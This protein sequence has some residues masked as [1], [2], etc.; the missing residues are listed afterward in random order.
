MTIDRIK[1]KNYRSLK[2]TEVKFSE[3][4]NIIV[5]DNEAGKSTLLEAINLALRCQLNR[6]PAQY[7]LHPYLINLETTTEFVTS[8][9]AG[10]PIPPPEV[11]I[12]LY[13]KNT[14]E[15]AD[16][17][18]SINSEK[19][20][21]SGISLAIKLDESFKAEYSEYI[22]DLDALNG[23]P[24]EYYEIEWLS[25]A[26]QPLTAQAIQV[27]SALIDP[28]NISNSYAANKYVLEMVR[29]Y[30]TKSQSVDLALAYRRMR[31]EFQ[32]DH[33]IT[34]INTDL[35]A[36]KGIV[37]EK[38]LSV[39]MDTTTRASWETG[40]IPH[41]DNIPLPLV[42]KGEQ[43]S[44]K[45]KLAIAAAEK[46]DVFLIEE[47]ENHLSHANLGKLINHLA[48]R[49]QGK[50]LIVSTHSSFVLNKL[51]IDHV[52]MFNGKHGVTLD[53]LPSGTKSYFQRLPGHDTLRMILA[54][55]SI[56]VEGP[57]DELIVQKGFRQKHGKL[58]LEAGVEVISV[59]TSFKRFLDIAVLLELDVAVVRDNDAD[60]DRQRATLEEF[61]GRK[62]I[63]IF[64]DGDAA[65]RTLEPQLIKANGLEKLNRILESAFKSD[66]DLA[67]YME[68]NKT[69][70]ALSIFESAEEISIPGYICDAIR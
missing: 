45:I 58:P 24:I 36:Q 18:G 69:D 21:A 66:A 26:G 61:F 20:D 22:K 54:S 52:M 53:H 29:D 35:G 62:H 57:S 34:A 65:A 4:I 56:L 64:I 67:A 2:N 49:C 6:R 1:I 9:K 44:V 13:L 39:A 33:R 19:L 70:C 47:P 30:L 41:L 16:L 12:E 7:E 43:N 28:G 51:G 17:R 59:G 14:M 68:N 32:G 31:D 55:R 27:K 42:G 8:L 10:K 50:Q 11:R 3:N 46:C 38:A 25:F 48:E 37:S 60:P 15:V 63:Q 40:V 23:I 5:G